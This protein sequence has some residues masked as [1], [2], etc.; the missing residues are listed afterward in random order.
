MRIRAGD[1]DARIA[2]A[3]GGGER[4]PFADYNCA[5]DAPLTDWPYQPAAYSKSLA[6]IVPYR[7]RAAHL[8]RFLPHMEAYF[9]RDKL[10]R[11]L[12]YTIHVVEQL[13]TE[14]F[15]RGRLNNAGFRLARPDADYVA[16]HDVD[17]LP[18]WADYSYVRRPTRL[19]WYG[20]ALR[21]NYDQFFGAVT[22][23]NCADFERVNGFS[24]DYWGWGFEDTDLHRRC[25]RAGLAIDHRDGTYQPLPHEHRGFRTDGG[26]TDEARATAALFEEKATGP[27]DRHLADGLSSLRFETVETRS[28]ASAEDGRPLPQI[29]HHF[30]RWT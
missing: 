30:I 6:I 1:H 4:C 17:Y 12:R 28:G 5:V 20:L 14:R 2:A 7:D 11:H 24:N 23:F 9:R 25:L 15:N 27:A 29:R 10:D 18:I 3:G 8:A 13:G 26:L 16:F 19:I 22:A 21:E